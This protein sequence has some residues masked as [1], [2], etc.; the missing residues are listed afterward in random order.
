M[1][2]ARVKAAAVHGS[3]A[4]SF[5]PRGRACCFKLDFGEIRVSHAEAMHSCG[6]LG[7]ARKA[8]ASWDLACP[9]GDAR[10]CLIQVRGTGG[11]GRRRG[12]FTG[13]A[14]QIPVET[15]S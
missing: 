1:Q 3:P 7:H 4:V 8:L 10:P 5:G 15:F 14:P 11:G 9:L 12:P 13:A 2:Q 6:M